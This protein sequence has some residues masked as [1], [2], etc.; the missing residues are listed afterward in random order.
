MSSSEVRPRVNGGLMPTHMN[1]NVCLLGKIAEVDSSGM[2]FKVQASD[3]KIV[4]VSR[5]E[6]QQ[7]YLEG[8]VEVQG[9]V[10][11]DSSMLCNNIIVFP[12]EYVQ[13]FDME[14]YNEAILL[15][16]KCQSL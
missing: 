10:T 12:S 7:D 6:P 11:S 9:R 15:M 1:Q 5:R 16:Q 8:V 4:T 2:S 13:G 14:S 3:G